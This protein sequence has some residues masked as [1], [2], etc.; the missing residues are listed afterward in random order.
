MMAKHNEWREKHKELMEKRKDLVETY[1]ELMETVVVLLVS[2]KN[3]IYEYL[4][5]RLLDQLYVEQHKY[6]LVIILLEYRM[7]FGLKQKTKADT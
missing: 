5:L 4:R 6:R 2:I 1:K 7:T 3:E